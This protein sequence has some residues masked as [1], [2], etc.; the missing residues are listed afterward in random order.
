MATSTYEIE[1]QGEGLAG[2]FLEIEYEYDPGSAGSY[3]E[4][5]DP[6][7]INIINIKCTMS[8]FGDLERL[9]DHLL[10]YER[11]GGG[12]YNPDDDRQMKKLVK[13]VI[14]KGIKYLLQKSRTTDRFVFR[15]TLLSDHD[16]S[17]LP[18]NKSVHINKKGLP[19]LKTIK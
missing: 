18:D 8:A 15:E 5:P 12:R 3:E 10:Q 19:F 17:T 16:L 14:H 13:I 2:F 6:D 7:S 1:T 9:K 11:D 4:P